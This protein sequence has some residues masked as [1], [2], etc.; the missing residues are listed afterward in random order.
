MDLSKLTTTKVKSKKRVGRGYGSG[1]GGHTATRGTKGQKSR[2]KV[3]LWFEGGQLK[4]IKRL[5]Y[6]RGKSRF[7]SLQNKP[8]L[9]TLDQLEKLSV[10]EVTTKALV[11]AH[12]VS[13]NELR[14]RTVKVLATGTLTK[15]LTVKVPTSAKAKTLIEKAGG[16]VSGDTA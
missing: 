11:D 6:I 14:N 1:K 7:N 3:P 5:P 2:S 16:T 10:K 13:E 9:I 12:Y 8:V 4:L 15:A